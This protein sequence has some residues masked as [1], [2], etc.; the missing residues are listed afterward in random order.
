MSAYSL[1]IFLAPEFI[2]GS[3]FFAGEGGAGGGGP[4]FFWVQE[5]GAQSARQS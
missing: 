1:L 5:D 3:G 4:W 2:G